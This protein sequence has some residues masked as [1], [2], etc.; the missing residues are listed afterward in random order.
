MV[1]AA[2]ASHVGEEMANA[3]RSKQW[4]MYKECIRIENTDIY[5]QKG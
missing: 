4:Y 5:F 2:P 3:A 1:N